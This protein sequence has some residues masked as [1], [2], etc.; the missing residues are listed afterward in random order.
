MKNYILLFVSIFLLSIACTTSNTTNRVLRK[1]DLLISLEIHNPGKTKINGV[2]EVALDNSEILKLSQYS[3]NL[4]AFSN[5][6]LVPV[7]LSDNT[8]N[9]QLNVVIFEASVPAEKTI[10][11]DIYAT[12][13]DLY[14]E[15]TKKTQAELWHRTTGTWRN[16]RYHGGGNFFR[17]DSLRVPEG[18]TDHTYF[19]KYEGPGWESDRVGY[20]MYLDWRN[21]NDI[22][23]KK[24][25][26]MVLQDVGVDGFETYHEMQEWGMDVLKVAASLGIGSIAWFDG[27][28]AV[29]VETSDSVM[30]K[31]E[32]DGLIRSQVKTWYYGWETG[33]TKANFLSLKTIDANS[34]LTR[35]FLTFEEPQNNVCTG[36]IIYEN[37]ELFE[38]TSPNEEWKAIATWGKQSLADDNM[39][40]AIIYPANQNGRITK[41]GLSHIVVFEKELQE[42]E[43][44]FTGAW[45]QEPDGVR[46]MEE[47]KDFL[48]ASLNQLENPIEVDIK[49]TRL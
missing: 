16:G 22:Y 36:F 37:I 33:A 48:E 19:I 32:A 23:G 21:A 41:D 18:F 46:T 20:R 34:R 30:C 11:V 6:K 38:L 25:T 10:K 24:T 13:E 47:F 2:H 43:Y 5:G 44:Y 12:P 9:Y 7:E 31:I 1:S 29:R 8:G 45:E 40:L 49:Q 3:G 14:P 28:K 4:L 15:F 27:E 35:E 17:F 42:V 26:D 39:G